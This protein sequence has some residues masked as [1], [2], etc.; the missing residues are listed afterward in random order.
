MKAK[1]KKYESVETIE[2]IKTIIKIC[3]KDH[4]MGKYNYF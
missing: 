4:Y 2:Q 3:I 1:N